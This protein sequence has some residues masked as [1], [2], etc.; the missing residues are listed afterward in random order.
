MTTNPIH[1]YI[2]SL[3]KELAAGNTTEHTHRPALKTLFQSLNPAITATN[4]P[5]HITFVGAPDFRIINNKLATGYVECKDIG[6]NLDEVLETAQLKRYLHSF[7]NLLLTDY[8]EFRWY[9]GGKLRLKKTLGTLVKNKIKQDKD[10]FQGIEELLTAFLNNEPEPIGSP[11]ELAGHMARLAHMIRE[12][13]IKALENELVTGSLHAQWQAFRVNLIPELSVEQFADMYSQTI[14]YGLFAAR[15]EEFTGRDFTRQQA[16]YLIPKTNPFLRKLFNY[17]AGPDLD[18][19]ITWAVDDL[20]QILAW[21]DMDGVLKDFGKSTGK[22][23]PVVHFYE[24]FLK[25]YDPKTRE[26]RGVYYTPLPVVSY[27]VRT[28]DH[29]LKTSFDKPQ[30]L[31]DPGVLVL[32]PAVGT[33]TFLYAVMQEIH[34]AVIKQGQGGTWDNY[35]AEKLLPRLFGFE[36]LMAP[37]AIAHLKLG[38]LLKETGYQFQT[39]RR[40]GIY[41]TNTLEEAV[42]HTDTIFAQWISEEANAAA[43]IKKTKPIMVV[44]GNPPYSGESANKGPWARKLIEPYKMVDGK[45]LGDRNPKWL[46]NDYVKFIAFG[47]WRLGLTGQGILG[48]ITSNSFLD[49][50]THRG[51]RQSLMN[52]FTDI[53]IFNLH[54][55]ANRKEI[56]PDGSKDENVFD[57]EEGVSIDIFIKES[58]KNGPA[59]VH[60]ADLWGLRDGKYKLLDETDIPNTKWIQLYPDSPL[61]LF[62]PHNVELR[63]EYQR[64]WS[65]TDIFPSHGPGITTA[66]DSIVIDFEEN[67]LLKNAIL[68]RD[69][70]DSNAAVCESLGISQ[71]IGWNITQ[72]RKLINTENN[73]QTLIK[74]ILYRPFD[75]RLIFYHDSLVWRTVKHVMRDMLRDNIG[76]VCPSRVETVGPWR[77]LLCTGDMVDHVAVSL[78]TI[79]SVFPLYLYPAAGEMQLDGCHRRPNLNPEF[80]KAFSEKLGMNFEPLPGTLSPSLPSLLTERELNG[81]V[82][83]G[84]VL[85]GDVI[86]WRTTPQLWEKLKPVARQMRKEPTQAEDILWQNLRNHQILDFKF[87]RQHSIERFIVDFYCAQAKLV[88]E[89]DGPIHQYQ[90]EE[91]SIRQTFIESQGLR[92]LRFSNDDVINTLDIVI[93]QITNELKKPLTDTL[94]P[95]LPSL[96][97]ERELKGEVL[98]GEVLDGDVIQW[99]TTPQ[100][101]EKLKPVAR[102]MRKEPTQAEDI[103]WQNLRNHRI[104]DFKFR[105]QHSI[106]RFIV[107]FYCS[108]AK[109]VIEIDGPIHQYQKEEDS[110]RQ[111]FI[112]NQGLRVLRFSNDDVINTLDNVIQQITS[113]LKKPLPGTLSPLTERGLGSEVPKGEV[114]TPE[115]IFNYAYAVF[116][117][118]AYRSRYAEFLKIDFPRL[119]LTSDKAL[120]KSL[121]EKGAALVALHLM[122]SPLLNTTIT[123]YEVKGEHAVEKVSYDEKTQRASINKTQYFEGLP[124]EVWNFHIG[125]YQVCEKW[126]KDRKNRKLTI[127]DIDHYQKIVVALKE[128]IRLMGEI[129]ETIEEHGS[130]PGAF[131]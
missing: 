27:I 44:L 111:T 87:R 61:Y 50:P 76:L 114:L 29:I 90:K 95:S 6:K 42:K 37:Y 129:D 24:T 22:T 121:V 109:L 39:D 96:S 3:E 60:Y 79:D 62:I 84:E 20:A 41:L 4:E 74:P 131:E 34:D 32:D 124:P 7:H 48:F 120:F 126:L 9:V 36:L 43:D 77:H 65:V 40:L 104:L 59:T 11:K 103:L 94:S 45:P 128:T 55:N 26:M 83:N 110:I 19:S 53:Y 81:E 73:L 25:E 23:D 113:E 125:G 14:A 106:E 78:K 12:I 54:G 80:I 15:C 56:A 86:Q 52:T 49:S 72:A 67:T 69:S 38:R 108:E 92:L 100:L 58:T 105:R 122:E 119:P 2:Q 89:I 97:T 68:F 16:A 47:Q 1:D 33:A 118:P 66:R 10:D 93:H 31:A 98:N 63:P 28:I 112:E 17:I 127:D 21:A 75:T 8:L 51:M 57:I 35:V 5:Q 99:R 116:H 115:S 82:L 117:S 85:D 102:Q 123:R 107:D 18:E 130:W 101:W 30:G 70:E 71:K 88:I 13:I 91:D 64:G 46:N